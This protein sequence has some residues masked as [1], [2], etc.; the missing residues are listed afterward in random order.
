MSY[1]VR[2]VAPAGD[3]IEPPSDPQSGWTPQ[4]VAEKLIEAFRI[5]ARLPR[6]AKPKAPG[7]AH[8]QMEYS[9]EER[10]CW[11]EVKI[12]PTRFHPS[13]K[14]IETME[15]RFEWLYAVAETNVAAALA[16]RNWI[17]WAM[18]GSIR[19]GGKK[20]D[21]SLRSFARKIGVDQS[22]ITRR[23]DRALSIIVSML[24]DEGEPVF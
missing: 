8:P 16:L 9:D 3:V 5:D 4:L 1:S 11:E 18:R 21:A 2:Y 23:K 7:S 13:F 14:E 12:D 6:V 10:E 24:C 20:S 15:E 17:L 22:T 19:S